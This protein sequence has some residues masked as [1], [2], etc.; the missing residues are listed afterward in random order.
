MVLSVVTP[1]NQP[2]TAPG[3]VPGPAQPSGPLVQIETREHL[4]HHDHAAQPQLISRH[5]FRSGHRSL[6]CISR[7]ISS[8][9]ELNVLDTTCGRWPG[10][11]AAWRWYERNAV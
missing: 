5:N 11:W 3:V 10:G 8:L 4:P 1:V 7:K 2:D 9:L 6:W